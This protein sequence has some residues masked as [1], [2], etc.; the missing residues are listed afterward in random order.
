M[1]A[2]RSKHVPQ[3][4]RGFVVVFVVAGVTASGATTAGAQGLSPNGG[5]AAAEAAIG[6]QSLR[7]AMERD[8]GLTG[9]AL[10]QMLA[11]SAEAVELDA[12]LEERLGAD[13]A[14]S[15]F[16]RSTGSLTVA[17][18]D[19]GAAQL[20]TSAGAETTVV[21]H[22]E[23]DLT[24]I[25]D[26]LDAAVE[27][28]PAAAGNLISWGTDVERN[29]VVVT[30]RAGRADAVESLVAEYGDAVRIEESTLLPRTMQDFPWLDGGIPYNGC[31]TGFNVRN[32]TTGARYFLTAG[33]CGDPPQNTV[34]SNGVSI[35]PFVSS[36]FPS[37][38]DALVQVT[39][40]SFWLQGP[41]VFSWPGFVTVSGFTSAPAGTPICKSGR[42]TQWTCGSISARGVSV[43]YF[44]SAGNFIGTVNDLVQHT[45]CVRPGDSGGSNLNV[46][47]A[48]RRAEGVTSGAQL[49][50]NGQ[51]QAT[52]VSWYYPV[53]IS[54]PFYG[55]TH[56]ITL[57]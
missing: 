33:H 2:L 14:G 43:D 21:S 49:L 1:R 15:W 6:E 7:A 24:A 34:A 27:A 32:T 22:S 37:F 19:S 23:R 29:Q 47:S 36:F 52:P 57:W 12:A 11:A 31:S 40:T 38:D 35:G 16:D 28:D 18:T 42:T 9:A 41:F 56:G 46:S 51:C 20:A 10:D 45:A 50:L 26:A 54:L 3:L 55:S 17:V 5:R 13:Y 48:T 39:N 25:T 30:A 8:F 4:V 53:D 44:D